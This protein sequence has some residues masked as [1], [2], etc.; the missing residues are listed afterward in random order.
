MASSTFIGTPDPLRIGAT[1]TIAELAARVGESW[2]Q[3]IALLLLGIDEEPSLFEPYMREVVKQPAFVEHKDML[4]MCL[5][6]SAETSPRP[7]IELLEKKP[8]KDRNLWETR[9]RSTELPTAAPRR[10]CR[11]CS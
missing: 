11:S 5:D 3:E 10:S 7:F 4:E 9:R 1:A 8:G 2:W 6:D